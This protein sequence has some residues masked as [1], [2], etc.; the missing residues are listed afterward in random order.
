[1]KFWRK[2]ARRRKTRGRFGRARE[3]GDAGAEMTVD[4][5]GPLRRLW[6]HDDRNPGDAKAPQSM[7]RVYLGNDLHSVRNPLLSLFFPTE[8]GHQLLK[9]RIVLFDTA[10]RH[11]QRKGERAF[12]MQAKH[13]T[14]L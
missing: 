12:V 1:M 7:Y 10:R 9:D 3:D 13:L 8:R 5:S 4:P 11:G 6:N 2:K 14:Q